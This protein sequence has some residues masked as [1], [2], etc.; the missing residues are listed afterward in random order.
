MRNYGK[1]NAYLG[2]PDYGGSD[3]ASY[4]LAVSVGGR[5]DGTEDFRSRVF[6]RSLLHDL[7]HPRT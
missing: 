5:A 1:I 6:Q 3:G 4:Y 7:R 2:A